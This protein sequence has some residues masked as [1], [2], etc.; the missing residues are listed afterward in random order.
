MKIDLNKTF[1]EISKTRTLAR[2]AHQCRNSLIKVHINHVAYG[3]VKLGM[4]F[5]D[6]FVSSTYPQEWQMRYLE[7]S[8]ASI[9]PVLVSCRLSVMPVNWSQIRPSSVCGDFILK[10][11][12]DLGIG[13]TG[14]SIPIRGPDGTFAIVSF[15]AKQDFENIFDNL[16]FQSEL[17]LIA[18]YMHSQAVSMIGLNEIKSV[19]TPREIEIAGLIASGKTVKEISLLLSLSVSTVRFHLDN[20]RERLNSPTV[21]GAVAK[22][23]WLGLVRAG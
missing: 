2:L 7:R 17:V 21:R 13:R 14:L 16:H 8:Y 22:A 10:E 23:V 5:K 18:F 15:T 20:C 11:A 9:D 12:S 1:S 19:L 3:L 6:A 4:Q